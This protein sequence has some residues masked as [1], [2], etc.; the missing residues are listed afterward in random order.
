MGELESQPAITCAKL[1]IETTSE[2]CS[3]LRIKT[4]ER[5]KEIFLDK[6]DKNLSKPRFLT[7]RF[8]GKW[9]REGSVAIKNDWCSI[10]T[11]HKTI[12][13]IDLH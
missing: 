10:Y 13:L 8:S 3:K 12:F 2:T 9:R 11:H 5:R 6:Q 1:T 4:P 7:N